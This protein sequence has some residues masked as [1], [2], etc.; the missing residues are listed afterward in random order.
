MTVLTAEARPAQ[1]PAPL[2]GV[3]LRPSRRCDSA[4]AFGQPVG[5]IVAGVAHRDDAHGVGVASLANAVT[6]ALWAALLGH[7]PLTAPRCGKRQGAGRGLPTITSDCDPHPRRPANQ[8]LAP[9]CLTTPT[10][11]TSVMLPAQRN[12]QQPRTPGPCSPSTTSA[13]TLGRTKTRASST[14]GQPGPRTGTAT[15]PSAPTTSTRSPTAHTRT[16]PSSARWCMVRPSTTVA[17]KPT[18]CNEKH[19]S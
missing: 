10:T 3:Q 4:S 17:Y 18:G 8:S 6:G 14:T 15:T 2:H 12:F 1:G 11:P 16:T 5:E 13:K 7:R 19:G 9:C